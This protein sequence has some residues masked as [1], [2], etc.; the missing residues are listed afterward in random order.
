[1]DK[2]DLNRVWETYIKIDAEQSL[3]S[4][5]R[6]KLYPMLNSLKTNKKITWYCFLIHQSR[7]QNDQNL[8]FHIRFEPQDGINDKEQVNQILPDFCEKNITALCKNVEDIQH[9]FGIDKGILKNEDIS[10]A[11]RILGEQS[12]WIM[13]LVNIHKENIDVPIGQITQF[14]HFYLNMLGLGGHAVLYLG[15]VFQF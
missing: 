12:E 4:V 7:I 1:M 11:W 2:P 6:S 3:V 13:N 10:E 8:Y 5:I 9:I 15:P 14:M